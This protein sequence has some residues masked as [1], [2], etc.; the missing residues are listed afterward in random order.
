MTHMESMMQGKPSRVFALELEKRGA[1]ASFRQGQYVFLKCPY[2]SGFQWHPFTIASAPE[3]KTFTCIIR[4]QGDGSW[5][6][7][8][9]EYLQAMSPGK[10]H[11]NLTH[12]DPSGKMVP[13]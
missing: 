7:K 2:V 10:Q 13:Q 3:A 8:V 9:Q 4:N 6:G 11:Y 12:R 5:T 1:M